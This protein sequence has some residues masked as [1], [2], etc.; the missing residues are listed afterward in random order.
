MSSVCILNKQ[1]IV[2]RTCTSHNRRVNSSVFICFLN[3]KHLWYN[4]SVFILI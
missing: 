3:Q 2:I 1:N 4:C